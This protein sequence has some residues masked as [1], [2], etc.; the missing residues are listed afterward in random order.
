[1]ARETHI[2]GLPWDAQCLAK[3]SARRVILLL[4]LLLLSG[5]WT[6]P[7]VAKG[8]HVHMRH[9]VHGIKPPCL[10]ELP[11]IRLHTGFDDQAAV[12]DPDFGQV[13]ER[14][15]HHLFLVG[16]YITG[17]HYADR[18]AR[19]FSF[20]RRMESNREGEGTQ[21]RVVGTFCFPA[22]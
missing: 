10:P 14:E 11:G 15:R 2:C 4:L 7:L 6:T 22:N 19:S 5:S 13:S 1:M 20:S 12:L 21:R 17:L 8:S 18:T 16:A 9:K 3:S